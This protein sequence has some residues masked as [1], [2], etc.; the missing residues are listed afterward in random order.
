MA[1]LHIQQ[2]PPTALPRRFLLSSPAW[3]M[4]AGALL[5]WDGPAAL[6]SRWAPQTLA[7]VHVLTLGAWGNAMFGSL[8][9][10]LPAAA[11]VRVRGGA[12][13]G[14]WLHALLNL[15]AALLAV[16]FHRGH[17]GC[18]LAGAVLLGAAFALL[19]AMLLPGLLQRVRELRA[20]CASAVLPAGVLLAMASALVTAAAGVAMVSVITGHGGLPLQPWVDAHAAWGALGWMLG[21]LASVGG[22]TMPMFQGTQPV[23]A[24]AQGAWLWAIAVVLVMGTMWLD[25]GATPLR[26][27]V[28]ACGL[29]FALAGVILQARAPRT[30]NRWLVRS[31]RVGLVAVFAAAVLLWVRAPALLVGGLLLGIAMPLLISGMQLEIVPFLGWIELTRRCPRGVRLPT[32]QTLMPE[33]D[34]AGVFA[35]QL[36]AAVLL[37]LALCWPQ[38]ARAAGM[39]LL[40]S[41]ALLL[42]RLL[43]VQRR[44]RAFVA[45]LAP[46]SADG[47]ACTED[48]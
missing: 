17:A 4:V 45:G 12:R 44:V 47:V 9:Q 32:V 46:M 25:A 35:A 26:T 33:R 13:A 20:A 14:M 16:G 8:L 31:W 24:R 7:L 40:A 5:L 27:G 3:V 29:V 48:A 23:P 43:G 39:G 41:N 18:L 37:L 30:R 1:K 28:A 2:A 15:G 11:G 19:A 21:L 34:K 38:A 36:L 22:V 42:W 10:F 6:Q